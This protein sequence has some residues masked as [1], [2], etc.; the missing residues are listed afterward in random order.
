MNYVSPTVEIYYVVL[1][2]VIA[3]SPIQKVNVKDWETDN[4]NDPANNADVTLFF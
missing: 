3:A 4:S 2:K 1:E